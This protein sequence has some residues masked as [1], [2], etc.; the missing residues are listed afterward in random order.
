[1]CMYACMS[2]CGPRVCR[3]PWELEEATGT[4]VIRSFGLLCG[5]REPNLD[6][7]QGQTVLLTT[8]PS[9]L[10]WPASKSRG[11]TLSISP[12][13]RY[14]RES[15]HAVFQFNIHRRDQTQVFVR[16]TIC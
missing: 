9:R 15:P 14:K 16:Q 6:S 5:C 7:L 2:L 1:M 12:R 4:G 8:E 13:L 11:S 10:V 3:H